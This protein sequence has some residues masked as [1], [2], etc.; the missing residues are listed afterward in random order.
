MPCRLRAYQNA[1]GAV[2]V[3]AAVNP[4]LLRG[5]V[6]RSGVDYAVH[7]EKA[8]VGVAR[9]RARARSRSAT[10]YTARVGQAVVAPRG[11]ALLVLLLGHV[12]VQLKEC[13]PRESK[14]KTKN[15]KRKTSS[16]KKWS[17]RKERRCG[18]K[19]QKVKVYVSKREIIRFE[20]W[21]FAFHLSPLKNT[22]RF[23][24]LSLHAMP[25]HPYIIDYKSITLT[26][27][28]HIP[29]YSI[30]V[31]IQHFLTPCRLIHTA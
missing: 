7:D 1:S 4:P 21:K 26:P 3:S 27:C 5:A 19:G 17:V 9:T 10:A 14:K 28:P 8:A 31:A 25:T 24:N 15:E 29:K 18:K 2:G 6:R 13:D 16:L 12:F 11:P 30:G 23:V 22:L 20:T